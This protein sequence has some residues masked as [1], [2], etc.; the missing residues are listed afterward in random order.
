MPDRFEGQSVL[1]TGG[2]SGNGRAIALRFAQEGAGLTIADINREPRMSDTP[3]CEKIEEIGGEAQFVECDVSKERDLYEAVDTHL[4][5]FGTI[6]IMVNNAG[7]DRQVPIEDV[8]GS[9]YE[10]LMNINLKGVYF[11]CQAAIRAMVDQE[12][13]GNI[14][15]MSSVAG[16]IAVEN[17]SLYCASKGAVTN[18]TRE[19]ALEHGGNGIRVNAL[20]P[21]IIETAMTVSDGDTAEGIVE[22]TPLGRAGQPDEVAGA[23]LFL[24]SEDASYITGHNLV[25]DGGFSV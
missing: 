12:E 18:L 24:A 6:N 9:D 23:A 3:T 16:L 7:V 11:G 19:L 22:Q 4:D 13:G 5:T 15:N 10:F 8:D 25:I 1:V 2:A 14:I 21:G 20:N 17:S